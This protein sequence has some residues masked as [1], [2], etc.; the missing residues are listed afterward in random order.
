MSADFSDG[1]LPIEIADCRV[2]AKSGIS[3][4]NQQMSQSAISNLDPQS[5]IIQIRTHQS[6]LSNVSSHPIGP[7]PDA[8]GSPSQEG[9]V[10]HTKAR[11]AMT[12][13]SYCHVARS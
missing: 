11:M 8:V 2:G 7:V 13:R 5:A 3:N 9:G 4:L 1:G 6:A 10:S 12:I